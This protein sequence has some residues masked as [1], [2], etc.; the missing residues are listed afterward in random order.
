MSI[1]QR[2]KKSIPMFSA[3][4]SGNKEFFVRPGWVFTSRR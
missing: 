4:I 1:W 3:L 2:L